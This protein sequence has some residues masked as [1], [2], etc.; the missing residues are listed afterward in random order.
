V[1]VCVCVCVGG[2]GVCVR[3]RV[4]AC[5]EGK[6]ARRFPRGYAAGA[7][8]SGCRRLSQ[9]SKLLSWLSLGAKL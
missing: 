2:W 4:R 8:S 9:D 1:C 5:S 6:R 7:N 3:A